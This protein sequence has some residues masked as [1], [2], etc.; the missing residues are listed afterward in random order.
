MHID[1]QTFGPQCCK[2]FTAPNGKPRKF[3]THYVQ[4]PAMTRSKSLKGLT[5]YEY[6]CQIWT[7]E[8]DRFN[9]NPTQH[10]VGLNT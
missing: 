6:I 7:K 9:I 8:P 10:L 1:A 5:P 2:N 3:K 4:M